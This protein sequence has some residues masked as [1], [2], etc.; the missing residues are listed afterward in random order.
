MLL[1]GVGFRGNFLVLL[2]GVGFRGNFWVLLVGVGF[3]IRSKTRK[4]LDDLKSLYL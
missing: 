2:V 4:K 3:I 1:V